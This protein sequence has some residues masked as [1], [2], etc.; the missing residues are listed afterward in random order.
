MKYLYC[1]VSVNPGVRIPAPWFDFEF[2]CENRKKEK[3]KK[4]QEAQRGE[5]QFDAS[6]RGKRELKSSRDKSARHE[7]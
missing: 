4:D 7:P 6:R 1:S 5:A 2:L 3:E